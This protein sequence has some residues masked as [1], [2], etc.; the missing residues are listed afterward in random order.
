MRECR[1]THYEGCACHEARH[2]AE[3]A[4]LR[5]RLA[6]L[7]PVAKA[8]VALHALDNSD[9]CGADFDR[10]Y[11]VAYYGLADAVDA[12]PEALRKEFGA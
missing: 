5:E 2:A 6:A 10:E 12:L 11:G 3:V 4:A 9:R 8:A 1:T 7:E